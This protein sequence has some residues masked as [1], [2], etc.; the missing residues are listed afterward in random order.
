[1]RRVFLLVGWIILLTPPCVHGHAIGVDCKLHAGRIEV[2]AFYDDDTPAAKAKVQVINSK[3]EI[4]A[5]GITDAR[6]AWS[7]P[8]LAPGKYEVRVD[9]GAGHR[10]KKAIEVPVEA[11]PVQSAA[12]EREV[13][14]SAGPTRAEITSTPWPK[15]LIGVSVIGGVG[16]AFLLAAVVRKNGK[17]EKTRD[18]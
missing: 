9:A 4:I 16:G 11:R 1:M 15:M 7:F 14:I 17:T 6:G 3:E 2:E 12:A 13:I 10:A 5:A 8:A 18:A